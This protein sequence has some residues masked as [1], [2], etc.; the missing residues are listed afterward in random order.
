MAVC[1]WRQERKEFDVAK[2][3]KTF[4]FDSFPEDKKAKI[5]QAIRDAGYKT[6]AN[7]SDPGGICVLSDK[8]E[9]LTL[10]W[11][12]LDSIASGIKLIGPV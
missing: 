10:V 3:M 12:K 11:G 2:Q 7:P 1:R 4:C 6:F 5:D 9:N 8:R